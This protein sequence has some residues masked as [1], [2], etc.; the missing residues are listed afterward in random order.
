[1]IKM[2][3]IQIL[4]LVGI[5]KKPIDLQKVV[6]EFDNTIETL[7][8]FEAQCADEIEECTEVLLAVNKRKEVLH[9]DAEKA[10]RIKDKITD[11]IS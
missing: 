6:K 2:L 4:V 8:Q 11:L 10:S 7:K 5:T 9:K 1:M 3:W